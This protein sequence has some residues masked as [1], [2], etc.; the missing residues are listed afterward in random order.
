MA[1]ENINNETPTGS[2]SE[3]AA[4]ADEFENNE[5]N[6][7]PE[8]DGS[9]TPLNQEAVDKRIN[10]LTFKRHEEK[11][12]R[13]AIE[14]ENERLR[15]EIEASR[16]KP[17]EIVIPPLPDPYDPEFETK[18][19]ERDQALQAK[20]KADA[21]LAA[22]R[23]HAE[24]TLASQQ[25]ERQEFLMKRTEDMFAAGEKLGIKKD[26]MA[27]A[28]QKVALFIKDG[29]LAD[30]ILSQDDSALIVR[31]LSSSAVEL[32]K[33]SQMSP[34]AASAYIATKIMPKAA[35]LKPDLPNT[36]DPLDIPKGGPGKKKDPFLTGVTFE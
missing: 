21:D 2:E 1:E 31:Y 9:E 6:V 5:Q 10:E 4:G 27:L 32:E 7:S 34:V 36:P 18:V 24:E 22:N 12:K 16:M 19:K 8:G 30:F 17:K 14:A 23:K 25:R 33:I 26:E 20:A 35:K 15:K 13:E 11:R 3:A 29:S 28:E